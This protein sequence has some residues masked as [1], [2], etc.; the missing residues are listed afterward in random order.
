MRKSSNSSTGMRMSKADSQTR[1]RKQQKRTPRGA[2]KTQNNTQDSSQMMS[3]EMLNNEILL[4]YQMGVTSA[5]MQLRRKD[6][7][8]RQT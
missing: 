6:L 3:S 2:E 5:L 8:A 4:G 1:S 7:K